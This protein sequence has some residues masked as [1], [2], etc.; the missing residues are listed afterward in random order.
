MKLVAIDWI[1]NSVV[2]CTERS[3]LELGPNGYS[4]ALAKVMFDP[5]FG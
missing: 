5:H 2:K 4:V 3:K 1:Q